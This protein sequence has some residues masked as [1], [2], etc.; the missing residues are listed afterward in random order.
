MKIIEKFGLKNRGL[1]W[2]GLNRLE[3]IFAY[4]IALQT[5]L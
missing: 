4:S 2:D 1:I 5:Y 3:E